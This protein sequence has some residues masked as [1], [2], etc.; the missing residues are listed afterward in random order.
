[1]QPSRRPQRVALEIRHEISSM[2]TRG[3]KDRRIGLVTITDVEMSKDLRHAKVFFSA[4]G[5]EK[6]RADCG[7]A[8]N[9]AAG[10]IRRELGQRIRMRFLPEIV[11]Y[12]DTSIAYGE[13]IDQ[14]L[15]KIRE[16]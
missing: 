7:I 16:E 14:L 9:H 11:F 13:K 12:E 4:M 2:V 6:E 3:L 15:D 8:L 5:S 1:M 10:W